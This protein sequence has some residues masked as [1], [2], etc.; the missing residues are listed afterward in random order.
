VVIWSDHSVS[1]RWVHGEAEDALDR[2]KLVPLAITETRLPLPFGSLETA[3]LMAWPQQ[4]SPLQLQKLLQAI[5]S[6]VRG[7]PNHDTAVVDYEV[8]DPSLSM[9]IANRV[10]RALMGGESDGDS[11]AMQRRL[12][13]ESAL[14][15]AGVALIEGVDGREVG[16]HLTDAVQR[17]TA[18]TQLAVRNG[19]DLV[20]CVASQGSDFVDSFPGTGDRLLTLDSVTEEQA[21]A[22]RAYGLDWLYISACEP[23]VVY[24]GAPGPY[25]IALL[26][27][28]PVMSRLLRQALNPS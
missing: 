21:A 20:I 2:E 15:D 23:V 10:S 14:S 11:Q 26:Q 18:A 9:R 13:L 4:E 17:C 6:K 8:Y 24:L 1:S 27:R 16:R 7:N 25:D 3:L 28:V 19:E 12:D 5:E 22:L